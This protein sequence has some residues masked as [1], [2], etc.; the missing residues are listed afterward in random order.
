MLEAGRVRGTALPPPEGVSETPVMV[1]TNERMLVPGGGASGTAARVALTPVVFPPLLFPPP[2]Q[3]G[4]G[5]FRVQEVSESAASKR[6]ET[7]R[8]VL[9]RLIRHP[10][11]D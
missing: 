4:Q 7:T 9:K 2:T 8:R 11:G 3:S 1:T 5:R 10:T 6:D